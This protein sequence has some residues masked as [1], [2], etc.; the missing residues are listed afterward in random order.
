VTFD[1][2]SYAGEQVM[3]RWDF[4]SDGGVYEYGW[5]I[6]DVSVN[7][8]GTSQMLDDTPVYTS[9]KSVYIDAYD[10]TYVEFS[11]AW[12]ANQIGVFAINVETMLVGDEDTSN[13][14]TLGVVEI[15]SAPAGHIAALSEGWNFVA[16]P[17][18]QSINKENLVVNYEGMDHDWSDAVSD[19]YV[20]D[21]LFGWDRLL[22]SYQFADTLIPGYGYWVY[23]YDECELK[24]PIFD[25]N[26]EGYITVVEEN[27]NMIGLPNNAP[28]NKADVMI[29][30]EG[31][32]YSWSDAVSNGYISD[33]I[34][35]WDSLLQSYTF[36][37][38]IDP[39]Y[40][41]W[42]YAYYC[43]KLKENN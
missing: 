2:S 36:S 26:F 39:G 41:Y 29:N 21:Y 9:S 15:A 32:D 14:K 25:V 12:D 13:D 42:F 37:D 20:S 10:S 38:I 4:G 5:Y 28:M 18:N 30:H 8:Q 31:T 22:Q 19:G 40:G 3:F 43:C 1:L 11:P 6:D 34:F 7:V 23:A 35:C 17:F 27:W 16:L 33:Y 24:A